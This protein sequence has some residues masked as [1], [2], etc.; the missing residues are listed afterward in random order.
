MLPPP[1]IVRRD[2]VCE[3]GAPDAPSSHSACRKG[4]GPWVEASPRTAS[5]A[6]LH[7]QITTQ[8][9]PADDLPCADFALLVPLKKSPEY[10]TLRPRI[11]NVQAIDSWQEEGLHFFVYAL[12]PPDAGG[13]NPSDPPVAV[14]TLHPE[15]PTPISVVVVTPSADGAEAE[16]V[17]VRQPDRAYT[18][19][20]SGNGQPAPPTGDAPSQQLGNAPG[21][22][23]SGDEPVLAS[24]PAAGALVPDSAGAPAAAATPVAD[25]AH[26]ADVPA[27]VA[28]VE[29]EVPDHG[30][31]G[32]VDGAGGNSPDVAVVLAEATTTDQ[33][34]SAQQ[35]GVDA[36]AAADAALLVPLRQSAEYRTLAGR[37]RSPEP[38]DAWQ[39]DGLHFF[40]FALHATDAAAQGQQEAPLAVFAMAAEHASPVSAVVVGPGV[41]GAATQITNLREPDGTDDVPSSA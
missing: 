6:N 18:A 40:A 38:V 12:K 37:L 35:R 17:D 9:A 19:P 22:E 23:P 13:V 39:E 41:N 34:A 29:R 27:A 36:A 30:T 7:T 28:D 31:V 32:A 4:A 5:S 33:P 20:Y 16:V 25:V 8:Y 2:T 10:R 3:E 11:A 15:E 24:E 1:S 14:F 26:S 21:D